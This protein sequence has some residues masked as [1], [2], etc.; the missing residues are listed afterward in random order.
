[1]IVRSQPLRAALN[2][3]SHEPRRTRRYRIL[4]GCPADRD[5]CSQFMAHRVDVGVSAFAPLLEAKRISTALW[6]REHNRARQGRRAPQHLR[7]PMG[8][9]SDFPYRKC[10][11]RSSAITGHVEIGCRSPS[12]PPESPSPLIP[13]LGNADFRLTPTFRRARS[14]GRPGALHS[15]LGSRLPTNQSC[16]PAVLFELLH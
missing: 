16:S 1:L 7:S 9:D 13:Q 15:Q 14:C 3:V 8:A 10:R 4:R 6:S 5:Q 11:V 2:F 12:A